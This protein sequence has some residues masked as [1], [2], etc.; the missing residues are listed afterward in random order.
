VEVRLTWKEFGS[1][2]SQIP[3]SYH[4]YW[5]PYGRKRLRQIL[6][7]EA[8]NQLAKYNDSRPK[9]LAQLVPSTSIHGRRV[10]HGLRVIP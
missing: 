9:Y 5:N 10:I 4:C 2:A 1:V 3:S 6:S 7:P 8:F